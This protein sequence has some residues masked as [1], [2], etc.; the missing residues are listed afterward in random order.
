[1]R[2]S[3]YRSL[4]LLLLLLGI[5]APRSTAQLQ[6]IDVEHSS[7]TIHVGRAGLFSGFGHDHTVRAPIA[8]GELD[9]GN[10]SVALTVRSASLTVTDPEESES[11]RAEIQKR[12]LGPDVLDV[13]QYPEIRFQSTRVEKRGS[14]AWQI[15]GELELH[16]AKRPISF[17]VT[18]SGA[19]FKGSATVKQRDFGITPVTVGGGTVK[20]KNEVTVEFALKLQPAR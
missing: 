16:G 13:Q 1:M 8:S 17:N 12:M 5:A 14:E 4:I 3:N 7:L 19:T 15:S 11:T 18:G 20:V 9:R 10:G 2:M 6:P